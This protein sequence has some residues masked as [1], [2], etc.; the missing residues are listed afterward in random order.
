MRPDQTFSLVPAKRERP[1]GLPWTPAGAAPAGL[2]LARSAPGRFRG[3]ARPA[4]RPV[5]EELA[6][7]GLAQASSQEARPGTGTAGRH[8]CRSQM[9][10]VERRKASAFFRRNAPRRKRRD[11]TKMRLPALRPPHFGGTR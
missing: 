3:P 4:L 11:S 10:Q 8:A 9:P 2:T 6:G 7:L 5:R 1:S